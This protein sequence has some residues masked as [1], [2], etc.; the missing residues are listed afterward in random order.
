MGSLS[1]KIFY[2]VLDD[3][4]PDDDFGT[5]GMFNLKFFFYVWL[6]TKF[7]LFIVSAPFVP[8]VGLPVQQPEV[9]ILS[10]SV[11]QQSMDEKEESLGGLISSNRGPDEHQGKN[12]NHH[13][14]CPFNLIFIF[15][16]YR[17]NS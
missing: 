17:L 15:I 12:K 7:K 5:V 16:E 3:P 1:G 2:G 6:H 11:G 13:L 9:P 10:P 4:A 14:K 8:A